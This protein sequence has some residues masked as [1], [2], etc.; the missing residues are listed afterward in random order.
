MTYF[1]DV[2][3]SGRKQNE[4]KPKK[5]ESL[6]LLGRIETPAR[7]TGKKNGSSSS[8]SSGAGVAF[9][10]ATVL[11]HRVNGFLVRRFDLESTWNPTLTTRSN[12]H[13]S[14]P[15]NETLPLR[16]SGGGGLSSWFFFCFSAEPHVPVA[17]AGRFRGTSPKSDVVEM[18]DRPLAPPDRIFLL[19]FGFFFHW[20]LLLFSFRHSSFSDRTVIRLGARN[21]QG[22]AD[23]RK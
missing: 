2:F 11:C 18:M 13:Q 22:N 19:F 5:I 1:G 14:T 4:K 15:A 8:S 12:R 21:G 6:T 7:M 10:M 16:L 17:T 23:P 20:L 3:R 9:L